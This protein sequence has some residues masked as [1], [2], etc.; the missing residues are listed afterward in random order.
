[1]E[2]IIT[3]IWYLLVIYLFVYIIYYLLLIFFAWRG[4]LTDLRKK[5]LVSSVQRHITLVIHAHNDLDNVINLLTSIEEQDYPKDKFSVHVLLDNCSDDSERVLELIKGIKI[6]KISTSNYKL[7]MYP[8]ISWFLQKHMLPGYTNALVFLSSTNIVKSNFLSR[9]NISLETS[10]ISQGCIATAS[11]YL[12]LFNTRWYLKNRIINRIFNAG[13]FHAGFSSLILPSGLIV[14]QEF[15]EKNPL[16]I[17]P[18]Q[19]EL[20]YCYQL[21]ANKNIINWAPEVVVYQ[22]TVNDISALSL[23]NAESLL[24]KSGALLRNLKY[25][26]KSLLNINLTIFLLTPYR[27][28]QLL[29]VIII[30]LICLYSNLAMFKFSITV[31]IPVIIL[32][33]LFTLDI[34]AMV[35]AK[36]KSQDYKT[37]LISIPLYFQEL[38][39]CFN[40]Y[41]KLLKINHAFKIEKIDDKRMEL[42]RFSKIK[43]F[44][45]LVT[46]GSKDLPCKLVVRVENEENQITFI[47][48]DKRFTSQ[49]YN[50]LDKAFEEINSKLQ[51]KNF[52]IK[53]CFNCGYFNFSNQSHSDSCGSQGHCFYGKEGQYIPYEEVVNIW[54]SCENYAP[55]EQ[56][57][58]IITNWKNSLSSLEDK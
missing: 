5:N 8:S 43:D 42:H 6:W 40:Y 26:F 57:E 54:H 51:S 50:Q 46:D 58:E 22:N 19:N 45:V 3:A 48:K 2:L 21:L 39:Y 16:N 28:V 33:L 9:V 32:V 47:F 53:S 30:T 12:S 27:I 35:V 37:V 44:D 14:T 1:M 56:R 31:I 18:H 15:L 4:R 25:Q 49:S 55:F 38:I 20:D 34:L 36:C 29:F 11:P 17:L 23:L 13:M 7:G 41:F 52:R 24:K 10:S